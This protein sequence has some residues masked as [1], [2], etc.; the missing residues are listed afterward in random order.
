[1]F[2]LGLAIIALAAPL[3]AGYDE[4]FDK[5]DIDKILADDALFTEYV[6]CFLD[7]G[8]CKAELAVEFKKI[9]PEII[10]EACGK[11][12]TEQKGKV[13][14]LVNA[15]YEQKPNKAIAFHQKYD[16][17]GEYEPKFSAFLLAKDD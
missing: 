11:C 17:T 3:A 6:E 12:T 4:M 9:I 2:V 1:M 16:P 14:K 7:K 15:L 13:R 5:I 10:S 8:P